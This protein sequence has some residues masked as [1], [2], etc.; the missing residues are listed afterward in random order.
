M[1]ES[2]Q[3]VSR[4]QKVFHNIEF[5]SERTLSRVEVPLSDA[6]IRYGRIEGWNIR[7]DPVQAPL[8][9]DIVSQKVRSHG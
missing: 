5:Q 3:Y 7:F 6:Y 1:I 8:T 9:G 2:Q 4:E